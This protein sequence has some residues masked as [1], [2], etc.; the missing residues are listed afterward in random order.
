[1]L[2]KL[3]IPIFILFWAVIILALYSME[4]KEQH[5]IANN[6]VEVIP[7]HQHLNQKP[8]A[9]EIKRSGT[10]VYIKMTTQ[11]TDIEIKDGYKYKAWTFNGEAPGPLLVVNEG[12]TIHFT[13][14][15]LDP[16]MDHSMD[17][18]AV[19]TAPNKGFANVKPNAEGTFVYEASSPG[20]FMY[21]CGTNPMLLHIAN[22]MHGTIIVQPKDG[23]PTDDEV[24]REFVVIQNE[25]YKYND[26]EDMTNGEP[27]QVVF[28]TKALQEGQLNTNGKVGALMDN[29][30][31]VKT[32]E[33]VR[34]YV[35]NMG[36]NEVSSFHVVGTLFDDVYLDGNPVN[37]LKGMQ[38]VQLPS[39]GGAIVEFTLKEEGEYKFVTHQV[40]H[41]QKGGVGKIIAYSGE[42]PDRTESIANASNQLTISA[43][44]FEYNQSQYVVQ[45]GEEV[46]LTFKNG[47]GYHGLSID[48]LDI[49]I[50]G[51]GKVTFTPEKPGKYIIYC[52]VYCGYGHK[53][54]EAT[55][56][57]L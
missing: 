33:K 3:K 42:I 5:V 12:D 36:P 40:N 9:P 7:E 28:S 26:I 43:N 48:E 16:A 24:D 17:F 39:S 21:H 41:M 38:T 1:V 37:H 53:Q 8:T 34:L 18:H 19:H 23:Y 45:S 49:H 4:E 25:W 11:I 55:L 22:G 54:M 57:V 56:V 20:V 14:E 47:E 35:A 10:N 52:N 30:L 6:G 50:Q 32:G 2:N 51:E 27:S 13:L 29:P 31:Q 15:N 46:T 44:N